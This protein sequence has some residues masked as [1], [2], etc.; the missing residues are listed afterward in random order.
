M[1]HRLERL[2]R[3]ERFNRVTESGIMRSGVA[4]FVWS[5]NHDKANAKET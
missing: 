4:S 1:P 2:K 5:R 3:P